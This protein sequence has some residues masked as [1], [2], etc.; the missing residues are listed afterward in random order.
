MTQFSPHC[1][2]TVGHSTH[3]AEAF[4]ELLRVHSI[5]AIADVRS[6]PFSRFNPQ[7]N[8]ETLQATLQRAGID[9]VFLGEQLGARRSERDCYQDGKA[10][11]ERIAKTPS[12]AEGLDRLRSGIQ[13]HRIALLC[14]E[15]DPIICHRM[16]LV[17]KALRDDPFEIRHIRE[18]GTAESMEAAEERL[19]A[20]VGLPSKDLF[21][22]REEL[23]DEAY[24]RQSDRIAYSELETSEVTAP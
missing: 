4:V 13:R 2:F 8:R 19:L 11:Y 12:F 3:E 6:S 14:A 5:T 22:S 7:F 24:E 1:L 9:Y 20:A 16:I 15:K 10:R 21:R 23:I 18:D 17:C